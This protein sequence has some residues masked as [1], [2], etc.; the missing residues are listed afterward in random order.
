MAHQDK[1]TIVRRDFLRGALAL[2]V[3]APVGMA[4]ASCA[5][6]ADGST[7]SNTTS[8][9]SKNPFGLKN[10]TSI[11]V[12]MFNGGYG[13]DWATYAAKEV[14]KRFTGITTT[15]T[16][17]TDIGKALQPRFVAGNPPD[18]VCNAGGDQIP[19]VSI[20]N[21][22]ETLDSM[23]DIHNYEGERIGDAIYPGV[24]D[25]GTY[26]DKFVAFNY[27]LTI[28]GI[29]Y[30]ASLFEKEGWE[31]PKTWD[32]TLALGAKAKKKDKYLFTFGKESASYYQT[33][34]INSAVKQGGTGI[35]T[36]LN[37]G[38]SSAWDDD[39][40]QGVFDA[41]EK[42]VKNGYFIPGGSGTQFTAAQA[43]WSNDEQAILYPSGSWIQNEMK[44][45]TKS[46]FKMTAAPE[47]ILDSSSKLP[48]E[49][50][51][52]SAGEPFTVPLK[53]KNPAGAKEILRAL[54]SKDAAANFSKT[55]LAPTVVKGSV[56][57]G[58]YG[59][60]ALQSVTKMIDDAGKSV[61]D[62]NFD[63]KYGLGSDQLVAWNGFLSGQL[64]TKGLTS[65]LKTL[66]DNAQKSS[67]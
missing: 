33:L 52:S 42:A 25:A 35:I 16:P 59:S 53:G 30:S 36:K 8:A 44:K 29:W 49:A 7:G 22:L 26:N 41:L 64:D 55:R 62:Y 27:V 61:F 17:T 34:A 21:E 37:N 24:K 63:A 50:V 3:M 31:P 47:P 9:S 5:S 12:Y 39:A 14:K 2:G 38:D 40:V 56:P 65:K 4:L 66:L 19:F 20:L 58:G 67:S 28:Y 10:D 60:T 13:Y 46:G 43:K 57:D 45:A 54:L 15:V 18:L 51:R 11:E 23:F 32:D 48:Y 1:P 6:P